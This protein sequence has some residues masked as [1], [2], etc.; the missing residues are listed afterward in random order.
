[1]TLPSSWEDF[2]IIWLAQF[3][4]RG[5]DLKYRRH[6]HAIRQENEDVEDYIAEFQHSLSFVDEP[7]KR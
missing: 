1:M 7:S 5:S 3:G 6:F 4:A 2:K